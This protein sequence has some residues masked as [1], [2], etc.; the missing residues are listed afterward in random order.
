MRDTRAA[1]ERQDG[2]DLEELLDEES[3]AVL[4]ILLAVAL[5]CGFA[6]AKLVTWWAGIPAAPVALAVLILA[7]KLRRSRRLIVRFARWVVRPGART[8]PKRASRT[9]L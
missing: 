8:K 9:G 2:H 1:D 5:E 6:F 4:G 3:I 7:L